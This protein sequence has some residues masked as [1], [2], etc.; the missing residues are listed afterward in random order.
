MAQNAIGMCQGIPGILQDSALQFTEVGWHQGS[1]GV[2][3]RLILGWFG[4]RIFVGEVEG[5]SSTLQQCFPFSAAPVP[6][7]APNRELNPF[8]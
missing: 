3:R 2:K 8:L 7:R 1:F 6:P 5:N 4:D